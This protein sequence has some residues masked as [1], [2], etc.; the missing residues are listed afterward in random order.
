MATVFLSPADRIVTRLTYWQQT[1][2]K[3]Y[4]QVAANKFIFLLRYE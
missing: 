3:N 4:Q 1:A 2:D